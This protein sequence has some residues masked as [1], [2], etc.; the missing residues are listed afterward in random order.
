[1]TAAARRKQHRTSLDTSSPAAAGVKNG[2]GLGLGFPS[3]LA[4]LEVLQWKDD[5]ENA[6]ELV[7]QLQNALEELLDSIAHHA[8]AAAREQTELNN[9]V[10]DGASGHGHDDAAILDDESDSS[11]MQAAQAY[12]MQLTL[13]LLHTLARHHVQPAAAVPAGVVL[14]PTTGTA[15]KGRKKGGPANNKNGHPFDIAVPVRCAQAAPDAAVRS[16]ALSLVGTLATAMP[17]AALEHVLT[18]ISVVGDASSE[19]VDAHSS[20]VAAQ[21]LGAVASAWIS[22][23]GDPQELVDAVV[24]SAVAA[25]A[26][27]RLPLLRALVA[28]LPEVSGLCMVLIG[29]LNRHVVD[30][31]AQEEKKKKRKNKKQASQAK[32]AKD[33]DQEEDDEEDIQWTLSAARSLP[34][35]V[36]YLDYRIEYNSN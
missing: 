32:H 31:N 7:P 5:V 36:S 13:A 8:A 18:V 4:I 3:F 11:G 33:D 30:K 2:G 9:G 10:G 23:G 6:V 19:L 27:R 15:P 24:S 26:P 16:A 14:E 34:Q 17:L 35:K 1:M 28:A 25:P 29:L 12:A 22:S 21:C 20:A